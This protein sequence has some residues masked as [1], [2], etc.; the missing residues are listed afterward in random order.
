[1]SR[2]ARSRSLCRKSPD[3]AVHGAAKWIFPESTLKG[4]QTTESKREE[5]IITFISKMITKVRNHEHIPFKTPNSRLNVA[6]RTQKKFQF[7]SS[8]S[9]HCILHNA[10]KKKSNNTQSSHISL[11]VS[12]VSSSGHAASRVIRR[13][14]LVQDGVCC[15]SGSNIAAGFQSARF[16]RS[17]ELKL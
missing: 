14:V 9:S 15:F 4:L 3:G 17:N 1:M 13:W 11:I 8:H 5:Q 7:S 2:L 12:S 16:F 6:K 10:K